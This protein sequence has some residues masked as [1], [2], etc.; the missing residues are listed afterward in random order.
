MIYSIENQHL[1]IEVN[2]TGAQLYSVYSKKTDTEYLW[3]GNP[4]Y[5]SGRA[6]NLFP[7]IGRRY[8]NIFKYN[9]HEYES[10]THGLARYFEFALET[11][12]ARKLVFLLKSNSFTL[13]EYPFEFEYRVTFELKDS[14]L[15][16]KQEALNTDKKEMIC[17]FGGHPGINVPFGAGSFE[18]C[19]LEF[20][21]KTA[22][23]RRTLA[24]G[25]R[26]MS[27]EEESFPLIDG[28][29]LTL[30]HGLFEHDAIILANTCRYVMLKSEKEDRYVAMRYNDFKYIGFWHAMP[31]SAKDAPFV[32]LEPWSALPARDGVI[33][34][35]EEIPDMT[36]IAPGKT[37]T[38]SFTLEI[39]E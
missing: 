4:A 27:G 10:R 19:Y 11:R 8:N 5:W 6:Y 25:D 15:L 22:V 12:S 34:T 20:R 1:K 38:C 24:L 16:V 3:Q 36:H 21:E 35:L 23:K 30:N 18:D 39:H 29:K 33:E 32:C 7:F 2:S 9:G 28:V 26:Y 17:A 14:E 37:A 13:R 31:H